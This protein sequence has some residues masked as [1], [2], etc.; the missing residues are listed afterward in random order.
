MLPAINPSPVSVM[1]ACNT[2]QL[3]S[4][5]DCY[6]YHVP[7]L[8]ANSVK[9]IECVMLSAERCCCCC[10]VGA[11]HQQGRLQQAAVWPGGFALP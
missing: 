3:R 8:K 11:V 10:S 4:V 1:M 9:H 7:R 6:G 5:V 2:L